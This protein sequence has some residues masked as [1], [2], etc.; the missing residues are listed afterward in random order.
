L[1]LFL[2][3]QLIVIGSLHAGV[4]T[5]EPQAR[6][7]IPFSAFAAAVEEYEADTGTDDEGEMMNA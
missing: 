2:Y 7:A 3:L 5:T 4:S 6:A 1:G